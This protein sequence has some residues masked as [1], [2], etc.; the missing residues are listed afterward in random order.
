[1]QWESFYL[2]DRRTLYKENTSDCAREQLHSG[3]EPDA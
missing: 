1:M 2:A 3:T